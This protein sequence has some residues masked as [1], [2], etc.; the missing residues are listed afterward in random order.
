MMRL[1]VFS[2]THGYLS[3]ALDLTARLQGEIDAVIHLGDHDR[4]G[5]ALHQRFP[6]LPV[7]C[8]RGNND[9][10]GAP[11]IRILRL[12]G[13]TL[14]LTHGHSYGVHFRTDRLLYAGEEQG[15]DLVLFGHTHRPVLDFSGRVGLLNPGSLSLPRGDAGPTFARLTLERDLPIR[16]AIWRY[17]PEGMSKILRENP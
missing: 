4:D 12:E 6:R 2:D 8:V 15:A 17:A 9:G 16:G 11:G 7:F 13:K 10:A 5:E 14:F 1:L 3:P